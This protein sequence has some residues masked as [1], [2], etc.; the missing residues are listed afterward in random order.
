MSAHAFLD[1]D[2]GK[3]SEEGPKGDGQEGRDGRSWAKAGL[4][5]GVCAALQAS[6]VLIAPS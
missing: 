5:R 1:D 4:F 6:A 3:G 2:G